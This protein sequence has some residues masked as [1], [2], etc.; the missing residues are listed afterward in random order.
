MNSKL[1]FLTLK[2]LGRRWRNILK[3]SFAVFLSFVFVTGILLLQENMYQWQVANAKK[4]FGDWFVMDI[5]GGDYENEKLASFP[6]LEKSVTAKVV[7]EIYD[8]YGEKT[9]LKIGIMSDSFIKK[10]SITVEQ[11]QLPKENNEIAVDWNTLLKLNQGYNIGDSID[12]IVK[13]SGSDT[14]YSKKTYILSGILTSYTNVWVDGKQI[15]GILVSQ[16]ELSNITDSLTTVY[17]YPLKSYIREDDYTPIY[18][19]ICEETNIKNVGRFNN[20]VY[21]IKPWGN[22]YIYQYMYVLIMVIGVSSITYQMLSYNKSRKDIRNIQR[23]LGADKVQLLSIYLLENLIIIVVSAL[24]GA[25]FAICAGKIICETVI[26]GGRIKFFSVGTGTYIKTFITLII[27]IVISS[28]ANV[29]ISKPKNKQNTKIRKFYSFKRTL[30]VKNFIGETSKRLIKSNGVFVNCFIRIFA[31][32][33]AVVMVFCIISVS[34]AYK[35]Y[36]ENNSSIDLIGFGTED[37]STSYFFYYVRDEEKIK[38]NKSYSSGRE[39][40]ENIKSDKDIDDSNDFDNIGQIEW[41]NKIKC[42]KTYIYNGISNDMVNNLKNIDGVAKVSYGYYETGRSWSWDN[43]DL[44]NLG[45]DYYEYTSD[46]FKSGDY[47]K[48]LF[49]SE[50]VDLDDTLYELL[51]RYSEGTEIDYDEFKAG[52]ISVVFK[53]SNNLGNYDDSMKDGIT[54][55]LSN[56]YSQ[57]FHNFTGYRLN[58]SESEYSN[59][60]QELFLNTVYSSASEEQKQELIDGRG[61]TLLPCENYYAALFTKEEFINLL[62]KY[63][64]KNSHLAYIRDLDKIEAF[65]NA[66]LNNTT[67]VDDDD[68]RIYK[69]MAYFMFMNKMLN[70]YYLVPAATTRVVKVITLTD[71]I[72]DAFREYIPEFGQYTMLAS[73]ELGREAVEHQNELTKSYLKIDTLP[74]EATLKFLPNQVSVTYNLQST[75]SATGNIVASYLGQAGFSYSTFSEEKDLLKARTI[76]SVMLY[77]FSAIV[78]GIVYILVSVVVVLNRMDRYRNRLA[79]LK[80]TGADRKMLV[81]MCMIECVRESVWCILLFP[82]MLIIDYI[83]IRSRIS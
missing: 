51:N 35:A 69:V 1:F 14:G 23:Q 3:M 78:A 21:E 54:L 61:Y 9:G 13:D 68:N 63:N 66:L 57:I 30:S 50:Y 25:A 79:I 36:E 15:P 19:R 73:T 76:E 41:K 47:G 64:G 75:F 17:C 83:I 26:A 32:V 6:Y 60:V 59:A 74:E 12:L 7:N 81:R 72:K 44:E 77:G 16:E 20:S 71:E 49:A 55:K 82:V 42:G 4:H 8:E 31:L 38:E 62:K 65:C 48:Y 45:S 52:N 33:M 29:V 18:N 10:N 28:I 43:M 24:A 70:E 56:Y 22:Q 46:N 37:K 80:Q 5:R 2:G 67:T 27:A 34:S 53:D 40:Y 11:G 39:K 58:G